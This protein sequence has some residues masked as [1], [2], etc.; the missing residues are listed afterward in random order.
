MP[1][2]AQALEAAVLAARIILESSGET[3][4]AEETAQRMLKAFGYPGAEILA[5]PTG[6]VLSVSGD[7][8]PADSR[9]LRI[10][11]R[12]INLKMI[13]QVND[14][15]RRSEN[16][17]LDA[18]QALAAL[19]ALATIQPP[20]VALQVAAF[21][22]AAGAF[23]LMA[24]GGGLE[25]VVAALCGAAVQSMLMFFQRRQLPG[26]LAHLL[27]GALVSAL[28]ILS[29]RA[30]GGDQEPIIT[31]VIMPL[32]PGLAMT[33]AIRDTLR[34]DLLSGLARGMEALLLAAMLAAGAAIVLAL[35]QGGPA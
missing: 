22:I 34:G 1:Q 27:S 35:M 16:G 6:F 26:M 15:S 17:Q 23:A 2:Q 30:L 21:S 8:Q 29:I 11:N 9:V 28:S 12:A 7:A 33:N 18:S 5:F 31:G 10:R 25:F 14:I 24:G 20:G 19:Q 3:Y 13:N 4:R 32:L